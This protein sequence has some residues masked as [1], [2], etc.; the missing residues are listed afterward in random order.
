MLPE[1]EQSG[2]HL[3][4]PALVRGQYRLGQGRPS[5]RVT[6]AGLARAC[7]ALLDQGGRFPV[8]AAED[9]VKRD[10]NFRAACDV[11]DAGPVGRS[12]DKL[13]P[14]RGAGRHPLV[15]AERDLRTQPPE[16]QAV[17]VRQ[18]ADL[19]EAGDR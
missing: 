12:A 11:K 16:R 15:H 3:G 19:P 4:P 2:L 8:A 1:A 9:Q 10:R 6:Q 17:P 13:E 18:D 14:A 5:Q 7:L